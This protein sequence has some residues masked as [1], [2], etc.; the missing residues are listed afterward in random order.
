M[1][2]KGAMHR[3]LPV[4]RPYSGHS[5]GGG[6]RLMSIA[7]SCDVPTR[8]HSLSSLVSVC[9]VV[10]VCALYM[11]GPKIDVLARTRRWGRRG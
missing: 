11:W 7:P 8:S 9:T 6:L 2:R 4:E 10:C 3:A 5:A 1:L